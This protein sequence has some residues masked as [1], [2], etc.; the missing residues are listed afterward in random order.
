[1]I[2]C[3][4]HADELEQCV[5]LRDDPTR[6]TCLPPGISALTLLSG[7]TLTLGNLDPTVL[8]TDLVDLGPLQALSHLR[9]LYVDCE[10]VDIN[11]RLPAELGALQNLTTMMLS[12]PDWAED[13]EDDQGG[14]PIVNLDVEWGEMHALRSLFVK[15]WRF[16][17]TSS[18]L[19]LATLSHLSVISFGNSRPADKDDEESSFKCFCYMMHHLGRHCPHVEL[20]IDSMLAASS[21]S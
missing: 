15:N 8:G 10:G 21:E 17:C 5:S 4:I 1:M 11:L 6:T 16:S 3:S 19:A 14:R 18:I 12:A 20:Y 7:L 2:K 9:D 13:D